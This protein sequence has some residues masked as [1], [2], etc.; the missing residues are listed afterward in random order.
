MELE[1]GAVTVDPPLVLAL[2]EVEEEGAEEDEATGV[3]V[4]AEP[5]DLVT[6]ELLPFFFMAAQNTRRGGSEC[7]STHLI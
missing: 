7:K 5:G 2:E 1:L 4:D 6:I 3:L